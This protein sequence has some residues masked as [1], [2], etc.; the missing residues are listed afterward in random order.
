MTEDQRERT[1]LNMP[2]ATEIEVQLNIHGLREAKEKVNRLINILSESRELIDSLEKT[3][4]T[5]K[6]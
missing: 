5:I 3:E 4:I 2:T 6:F 1:D